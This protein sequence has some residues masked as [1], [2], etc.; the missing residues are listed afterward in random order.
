LQIRVVTSTA[1]QI[2]TGQRLSWNWILPPIT[3]VSSCWTQTKCR[4]NESCKRAFKCAIKHLHPTRNVREMIDQLT[5]LITLQVLIA[6]TQNVVQRKVHKKSFWM[7]Y[8]ASSSDQ[9]CKRY[10]WSTSTANHFENFPL[11]YTWSGAN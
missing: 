1:I 2:S 6:F 5:P 7:R 10:G 8:W 4:A 11:I 3:F 9:K